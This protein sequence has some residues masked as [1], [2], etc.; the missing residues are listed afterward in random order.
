ME[1]DKLGKVGAPQ[2][3]AGVSVTIQVVSGS[4]K[5]VK[6]PQPSSP[7]SGCLACLRKQN[8]NANTSATKSLPSQRRRKRTKMFRFIGAWSQPVLGALNYALSP[9]KPAYKP[10]VLPKGEHSD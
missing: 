10:V 5:G 4:L 8:K 7:Q 2:R 3:S 1:K 6:Q 9:V